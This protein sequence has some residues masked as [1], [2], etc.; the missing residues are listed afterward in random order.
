MGD[1]RRREESIR[2]MNMLEGVYYIRSEIPLDYSVPCEG[3]WNIPLTKTIMN[4]LVRLVPESLRNSS[5]A[6]L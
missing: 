6:P 3:Q 4:M 5:I 2:D 1:A